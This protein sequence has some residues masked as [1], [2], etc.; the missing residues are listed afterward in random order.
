MVRAQCCHQW[1]KIDVYISFG[2]L[3]KC[4]GT[5]ISQYC[6]SSYAVSCNK[7][8]SRSEKHL[9]GVASTHL[10][11]NPEDP[12]QDMLRA[13]Q[14][15]NLW[16]I[17]TQGWVTTWRMERYLGNKQLLH[18]FIYVY[19][20]IYTYMYIYICILYVYIYIYVYILSLYQNQRMWFWGINLQYMI[21][22]LISFFV[23]L[24]AVYSQALDPCFCF[25]SAFQE[26]GIDDNS[27]PGIWMVNVRYL[28]GLRML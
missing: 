28:A 14:V 11:R 1:Q 16:T 6:A 23:I 13:R 4:D 24:Y 9:A 25:N 2:S 12:T 26:S 19:I 7:H 21:S 3:Q 20:Y 22:I 5:D 18:E 27:T 8:F 10:Q 15:G 17:V